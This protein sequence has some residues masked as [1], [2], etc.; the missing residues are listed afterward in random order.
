MMVYYKILIVDGV[1]DYP[2]GCILC[3]AYPLYGYMYCK[4]ERIT[5][6]RLDWIEIT[7]EEFDANCPEFSVTDGDPLNPVHVY[8]N[9]TLD[10]TDANRFLS[11]DA[12]A[13]ITI[14]AEIFLVGAE[15]EVFRNTSGAVKIAAGAGVS[16]AIPGNSSLVTAT[17]TITDQYASVVLKQISDNVWSIQGAI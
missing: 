3:C 12:A 15:L 2:A 10:L 1:F 8:G 13:T 17:Q 7:A 5:E 9:K 6:A 11:V 4:F 14:P 16:F